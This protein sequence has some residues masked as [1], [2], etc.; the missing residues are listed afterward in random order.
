MSGSIFRKKILS[1]LSSPEQ[2]DS[3]ISIERPRHWI[4]GIVIAMACIAVAAW[5]V[6]GEIS[7]RVDSSGILII[8]GSSV[9]DIVAT[10]EGL[11]ESIHIGIGD[12]VEEGQAIATIRQKDIVERIATVEADLSASRS[13]LRQVEKEIAEAE[14]QAQA[15]DDS[16]RARL[17][18]T[19]SNVRDRIQRNEKQL[20]AR[21]IL[22]DD[23]IITETD[24][25][26]S[27]SQL[28][29]TR[30]EEKRILG[31]IDS[32]ARN[33][34]N[35]SQNYTQRLG[36]LRLNVSKSENQLAELNIRRQKG[37]LVV[38]SESGKVLELKTR[39]G[40]VLGVG[41]PVA[42]IETSAGT[43]PS[44]ITF[45]SFVSPNEGKKVSLG[46]RALVSLSSADSNDYGKVKGTVTYVSEFPVSLDTV[47]SKLANKDLARDLFKKGA[48]YEIIVNLNVDEELVS[49]QTANNPF[50]WTAAK[51]NIV[52]VSSGTYATGEI[53]YEVRSPI[54][55]FIPILREWLKI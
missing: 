9:A 33:A 25:E 43:G 38:A 18:E 6:Y 12:R 21:Q 7:E 13:L 36:Q 34:S 16:Q 39:V 42:T 37:L 52:N 47:V 48:P 49:S 24:L 53:I 10:S 22:F 11:V 45:L 35:R 41:R 28:E 44:G 30:A 3:M 55:L 15:I 46:Q 8:G 54:T 5:S 23:K 17:Q 4:I 51:G 1:Q 40:A 31:Q 29:Q 32:L 26:R 20:K 14:I 50:E 19:L 27:K 2:L